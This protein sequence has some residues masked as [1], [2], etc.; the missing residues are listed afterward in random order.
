M[1]TEIKNKYS[2]A[3][4]YAQPVCDPIP[5]KDFISYLRA[6]ARTIF[7]EKEVQLDVNLSYI[8]IMEA[9][10]KKYGIE[11]VVPGEDFFSELWVRMMED[12]GYCD[13]T[14]SI[15]TRKKV[16]RDMRK[17][18]NE[19]FLSKKL[20]KRRVLLDVEMGRY[21]RFFN[22]TKISRDAIKWFEENGKVVRA[23]PV[24]INNGNNGINTT[25]TS[26]MVIKTIHSIT[27]RKL[28][29]VTISQKIYAAMRLLDIIGKKGFEDVTPDDVKKFREYC[30]TSKMKKKDDYTV[31]AATFFINI[32]GQGFIINKPFANVS[33]KKTSNS[34]RQDFIGKENIDK[35]KDLSTVDYNDKISVRDRCMA[36][37]AY[38][39]TLRIGGFLMLSLPDLHKGTDDEWCTRLRSDIQKGTK[40][41]DIMYFFFPETKEILEKYLAVRDKFHPKTDRLFVSNTGGALGQQHCRRQFN[42]LCK[43]LGIKTYYGN[44]ATP[45]HLRHSF[46]TLNIAP[47]GLALP[48]YDIMQRLHHTRLEVTERHYIHKNPYLKKL[49]HDAYKQKAQK[50]TSMEVLDEISLADLEHWLSDK[51]GV[52]PSI[53]GMIRSKHRKTFMKHIDNPPDNV[54]YL[55]EPEALDR[56]KH[57][58]IS[59]YALRRYGLNKGACMA[60]GKRD[61][62]RYG[63]NFR[64]KE[65]FID[66]L[67]NN[68]VSAKELVAKFKMSL[69][70][71]Y[72]RLKR[73]G[74]RKTK[75]GKTCY[76]F[77][78]DCV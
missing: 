43:E 70:D 76:V 48:I 25:N 17:I 28:L 22:L 40:E 3:D 49:K 20:T 51:I 15:H 14:Y 8:R 26:D 65:D 30:N 35:L 2:D 68:W 44:K 41:E 71:F 62:C 73:N 11:S 64:Y 31:D 12:G 52:E 69:S 55:S 21:K 56:L 74:W 57:L 23:F 54:I 77:K 38:D 6:G 53:I 24:Y 9:Y 36:L 60:E 66:D 59:A 46:A 42:K 4:I 29:P 67:A 18:V 72:R 33:L 7:S 13:K 58:S 1:K 63:K 32:Q 39:L 75:I 37:V 34:V 47:L 61:L 78:A 45:H 10:L 5:K 50:K 19:Y 27:N 16:A